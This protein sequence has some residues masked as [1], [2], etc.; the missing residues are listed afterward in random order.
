[1]GA[2]FSANHGQP[3]FEAVAKMFS[4]P[5]CD[6]MANADHNASVNLHRKFYGEFA[7]VKKIR[8]GVYRVTK[9]DQSPVDVE[10]EQIK[11]RLAPRLTRI[12]RS[13]ATPF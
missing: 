12:C 4:C 2:R 13:E 10:M 11:S 3:Q 7:E 5:E 9:P 6:Y 8:K 1:M